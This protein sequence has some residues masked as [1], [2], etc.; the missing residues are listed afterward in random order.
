MVARLGFAIATS[1]NPDILIVDEVLGVGDY[2]FRAKCEERIRSMIKQGVTVL[3]VSHDIKQIQNMCTRAIL[4]Q[5]GEIA[6]IGDV[7][8]VCRAYGESTAK[9]REGGDINADPH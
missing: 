3:L 2:K 4:L 9:E 8:E 5:Q 1:V 7:D 6:C